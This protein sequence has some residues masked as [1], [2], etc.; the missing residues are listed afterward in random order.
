VAS[1]GTASGLTGCIASGLTGRIARACGD[2]GSS[3]VTGKWG[4][5]GHDTFQG[6][7]DAFY[8]LPGEFDTEVEA[9]EGARRRL[10]EL[11]IEQP[12]SSSGGQAATGIQDRVYVVRPDGTIYRFA[13][14]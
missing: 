5:M 1:D 12:S 4:L 3:S 8:P 6:G 14:D 9:Q 10:A 11:E 7:P 13:G 2:E